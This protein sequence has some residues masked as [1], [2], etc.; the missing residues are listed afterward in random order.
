[1]KMLLIHIKKNTQTNLISSE[2]KFPLKKK[3][4]QIFFS[5]TF[6]LSE[7]NLL[8]LLQKCGKN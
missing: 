2:Q 4:E 8:T 6:T 3:F 5:N 7:P 1:M